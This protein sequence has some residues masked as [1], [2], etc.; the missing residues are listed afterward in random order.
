MKTVQY[1]FWR[2]SWVLIVL[3]VA[4][5]SVWGNPVEPNPSVLQTGLTGFDFNIVDL[6]QIYEPFQNI[7][8]GQWDAVYTVPRNQMGPLQLVVSGGVLWFARDVLGGGDVGWG[9]A[10]GFV[11][12][13]FGLGL[14]LISLWWRRTLLPEATGKQLEYR[15]QVWVPIVTVVGGVLLFLLDDLYVWGHWCQLIVV[16][17]WMLSVQQL[18]SGRWLYASILVGLSI[19][20]EPW[21]V[22]GVTLLIALSQRKLLAVVSSVV[23]VAVGSLIWVGF[24]VQPGFAAGSFVWQVRPDSLWGFLGV[25]EFFWSMRFVQAGLVVLVV[26]VVTV[27][28]RRQDHTLSSKHTVW[29][30]PLLPLLI[31]STRV[32]TDTIYYPYYSFTIMFFLTPLLVVAMATGQMR[33]IVPL[34][35]AFYSTFLANSNWVAGTCAIRLDACAIPHSDTLTLFSPYIFFAITTSALV[36]LLLKVFNVNSTILAKPDSGI[37]HLEETPVATDNRDV[38]SEP[39][40]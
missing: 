29:L 7:F 14:G 33:I 25:D 18:L 8:G 20:F 1:A 40:V 21:G 31:M 12:T 3:V 34:A 27:L 39:W 26:L 4:I 15:T 11:V 37:S 22:F 10:R 9:F 2:F 6:P 36:W 28:F 16:V 5:F 38:T 19:G 23:S 30:I 17:L 13:V 32:V 35:I 24:V